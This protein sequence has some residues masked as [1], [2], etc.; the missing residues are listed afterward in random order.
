[1]DIANSLK[2]IRNFLSQR[3]IANYFKLTFS[4]GLILFLIKKFDFEKLALLQISFIKFYL[5]AFGLALLSIFLMTYRWNLLIQIKLDIKINIIK[6]YK[7]YLIGSF[8]NIFLPGALGGD[9]VRTKQLMNM[10]KV[11]LSNA[12]SITL[13]ERI[14]GLY[15]L[16][17]ILSLSLMFSNYPTGFFFEE[18]FNYKIFQFSPF[19]VLSFLPLLKWVLKKAKNILTYSQI[20]HIVTFSLLAQMADIII[21]I[22]FTIYFDL[23]IDF[24][25]FFFIMP[26]VYFSTVLPISLGGLG[27]RES[28]F[29]GLMLLYGVDVDIAILISLL[30]YFTK[31]CLGLI[32]YVFYL[33]N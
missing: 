15:A 28:V 11:S 26:L 7:T 16:S 2:K 13:I 1:M 29:S 6:L 14:S 23:E 4:F 20:L 24:F 32:G 33:K 21:A 27:V 31:F 18:N 22:I 5:V 10:G 8:F 19:F 3:K 9:I 12:A 17:I 25:A 30:M